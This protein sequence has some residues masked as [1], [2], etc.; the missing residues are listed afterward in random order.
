MWHRTGS[1]YWRLAVIGVGL[2]AFAAFAQTGSQ[3][4]LVGTLIMLAC[5][6]I[7]KI[8]PQNGFRI[9]F[10]SAAFFIV[11]APILMGWGVDII[12]RL[13]DR[14]EY[15][16]EGDVNEIRLTKFLNRIT[17]DSQTGVD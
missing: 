3:T 5:M 11:A 14:V 9:T 13:M 17:S 2:A 1:D 12:R 4:A 16:T 15:I 8:S 10:T 6:A 7:I